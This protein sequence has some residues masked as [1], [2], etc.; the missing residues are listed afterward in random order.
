MIEFASSSNYQ[1]GSY[2][3]S[4]VATLTYF[5]SMIMLWSAEAAAEERNL[6]GQLDGGWKLVSAEQ[7]LTDGTR[8]PSLLYGPGGVSYLIF[9]DDSESSMCALIDPSPAKYGVDAYCGRYQLNEAEGYVVFDVEMDAVPND[10]GDGLKRFISIK[11]DTLK[12]R[13]ARPHPGIAEYTLTW[14]R[15]SD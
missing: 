8:S 14:Q 9:A 7:V 15:F 2:C 5:A 3:K 10:V 11:G 1:P 13:T 12:L 6:R 4:R